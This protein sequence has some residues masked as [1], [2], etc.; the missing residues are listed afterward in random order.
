MHYGEDEF[1]PWGPIQDVKSDHVMHVVLRLEKPD[2]VLFTGN[3]TPMV[4]TGTHWHPLA[5]PGTP[6]YPLVPPGTPHYWRSIAIAIQDYVLLLRLAR[7][8]FILFTN[9]N[10]GHWG[11]PL[12]GRGEPQIK[13]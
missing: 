1:T 13:S 12:N 2:F 10:I 7:Q 3:S 5:P 4:P 6:W 11:P 8:D 9:Y